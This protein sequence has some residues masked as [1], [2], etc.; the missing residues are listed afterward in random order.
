M[1]TKQTRLV[2]STEH[3]AF[4]LSS[5]FLVRGTQHNGRGV[6]FLFDDDPRLETALLRFMNG[7]AK[8]EPRTF[9]RAL[10]D[11]RDLARSREGLRR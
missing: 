2:T 8:V 7:E 9:L 4:L 1:S 3:A 6:A 10:N 5:G 11:L